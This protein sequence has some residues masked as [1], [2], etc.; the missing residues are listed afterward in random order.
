MEERSLFLNLLCEC[1][2]R[3]DDKKSMLK[4]MV[5]FGTRP[6]AI[7]MAPVILALQRQPGVETIVC[8]TAQHRDMLDDALQIFGIRPEFDLNIMRSGQT[9][10]SATSAVLGGLTPLIQKV[11]PDRALVHGDTTTTFAAT[12]ACFY[13]GVPVGHVEAGLRT[14]NLQA[15]WPEEFNR[16]AV[17]IIADLLWA[18]T[19]G[20]AE[21]LRRE[22][23]HPENVTVTGN[24][25]IDALRLTKA[26][27]TADA[28]MHE[29]LWLRLPQLDRAK[30]LILVT[31]HRRES[32][33]GG[34]ARICDALN[35][36]ARRPDI[37]IVWPLHPNPNVSATVGNQLDQLPNIH[38]IA[39]QDY[40]TF[41]ALMMRAELIVTDSGGIQEE[42]PALGK[43]VLVTRDETERPEVIAAGTARLVGTVADSIYESATELLDDPTTYA[44]MSNAQNPFGDGYA[45]DR[46]VSDILMRHKI[47]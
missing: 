17:D 46:I 30:R 21:A 45:A 38:I 39:P 9:L 15:P 34:L 6:E 33:G 7:K 27:I 16:R 13:C 41:V 44:S 35:R 24:T 10:A 11:R 26:R 25:V 12:V 37:E 1:I 22:G 29:S 28:G 42:A 20:A 3:D 2:D 18:P 5:I 31:G 43:P 8:V 14:G 19:I 47:A 32:F 36:L 23:A 4:V 40:L